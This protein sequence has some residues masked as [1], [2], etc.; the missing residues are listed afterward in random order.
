VSGIDLSLLSII[1]CWL[2]KN[3]SSVPESF[4][5]KQ[6]RNEAL[7]KASATAAAT[8]AKVSE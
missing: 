5:K 1:W 8:A 6:A 4:K 3:M 2:N 7:A